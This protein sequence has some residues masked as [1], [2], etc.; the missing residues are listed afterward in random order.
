MEGVAYAV[1]KM[2]GGDIAN[3]SGILAETETLDLAIVKAEV[4]NRVP[5]VRPEQAARVKEGEKI[6]IIESPA[7]GKPP[8][9]QE[10]CRN[11]SSRSMR[12]RWSFR[13]LCLTNRWA[14]R[15]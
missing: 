9:F 4:E 10:W 14:R 3:I 11:G 13:F 2:S 8:F 7:E 15:C 6:A 12:Y 5:F 1:A